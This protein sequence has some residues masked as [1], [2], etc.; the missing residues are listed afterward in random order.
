MNEGVGHQLMKVYVVCLQ[1]LHQHWIH[2]DPK[3]REEEVAV[4]NDFIHLGVGSDLACRGS[5]AEAIG[6]Q[7]L[8]YNSGN[9]GLAHQASTKKG[10]RR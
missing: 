8:A 3:A 7:A 10:G 1:D 2:R 9:E 6:N 4:N 5:M